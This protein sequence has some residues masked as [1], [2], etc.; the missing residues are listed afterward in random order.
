MLRILLFLIC[1]AQLV[2]I[3]VV[4]EWIS[5]VVLGTN[6]ALIW[7]TLHLGMSIFLH[8]VAAGEKR[9]WRHLMTWHHL[10]FTHATNSNTI[11]LFVYWT[12][13]HETNISRPEIRDS[14]HKVLFMYVV[15]LAPS[16]CHFLNWV[17][18]DTILLKR[19]AK[20]LVIPL[21]IYGLGLYKATL[22]RGKAVYP[23]VFEF[24]D[25]FY[26]ALRNYIAV[27]ICFTSFYMIV[28]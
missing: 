21:V 14:W 18:S 7:V 19:S 8:H 6:H 22:A 1:I 12:F 9:P 23:V 16:V 10:I 26:G 25:D 13:L 24:I 3:C 17:I 20:W 28:A 15:H 4:F 27:T 2:Y 5:I 11:V